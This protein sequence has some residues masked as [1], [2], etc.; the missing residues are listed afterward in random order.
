MATLAAMRAQGRASQLDLQ[1]REDSGKA[2]WRK[3]CLILALKN[4]EEFMLLAN[5]LTDKAKLSY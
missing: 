1:R 3:W 2:T 4:G 5:K